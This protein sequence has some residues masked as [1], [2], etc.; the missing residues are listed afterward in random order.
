MKNVPRVKCRREAKAPVG[1][2]SGLIVEVTECTPTTQT[3]VSSRTTST[4]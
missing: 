4:S 1:M 2:L 3:N